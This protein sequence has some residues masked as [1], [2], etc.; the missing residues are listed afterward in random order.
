MKNNVGL[1][2]G[3][4]DKLLNTPDDLLV[5]KFG[6]Y[7]GHIFLRWEL[8]FI[9]NQLKED[10]MKKE[11]ASSQIQKQKQKDELSEA[12]KVNKQ[13]I[14][15]NARL[16]KERNAI[17]KIKASKSSYSI[18][19]SDTKSIE[20]VAVIVASDWHTEEIV[21]ASSV[22]FLNT[23]NLAVAEGRIDNFF[24][25]AVKLLSIGNTDTVIKKV[26]LALLGDFI[27]GNIHEELLENT[28]L[29]PVEA[30]IWV[31]QRLVAG[32]KYFLANTPYDFVVVCHSGNHARIT[33][34]T[35]ISTESGN[36]LEFFMYNNL[37]EIFSKEKRITFIIPEGYHSY[38][39]V[40]GNM[41][42]FHHG[43]G[44]KYGGGIGGIFIPTYK[45]ISQ[46][47]KGKIATLDVFGH[48]HQ[49]KNGG[50]FI[51][52]GSLIGYN[53]YAIKIK[54]DFERPFQKF[55]MITSSGIVIGEYPIF[56]D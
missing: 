25:N 42:R 31:Q 43:H 5:R 34:K 6:K 41:I 54:A 26:I 39:D 18:K 23:F 35:H 7:K 3:V 14:R 53:S 1:F 13:L 30:I 9:K 15:E 37:R 36:S 4:A 2:A 16:E 19:P 17:L 51:C 32:I 10:E 8:R 50:N 29:R 45:A 33:D 24:K 52:N 49:L 20:A 44:I 11:T 40:F 56:L 28:S 27:S 38:V 46:W 21:K 12:N 22:N 47:N 48:Y 55:F